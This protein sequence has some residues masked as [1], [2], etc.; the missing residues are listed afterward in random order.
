MYRSSSSIL[1][2]SGPVSKKARQGNH[3]HDTTDTP[4]GSSGI[5]S[6]RPNTRFALNSDAGPSTTSSQRA[7]SNLFPPSA[8]PPVKPSPAPKQPHERT[9]KPLQRDTMRVRMNPDSGELEV[10]DYESTPEY[11]ERLQREHYSNYLQPKVCDTKADLQA[12]TELDGPRFKFNR[13]AW[14][15]F[16]DHTLISS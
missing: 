14:K 3:V 11:R 12:M 8:F 6:R 9:A 2:D 16:E 13:D 7:T 4:S 1:E 10:F 5:N 15:D